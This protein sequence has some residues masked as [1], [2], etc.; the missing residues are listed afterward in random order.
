MRYTER[1]NR[2]RDDKK[3]KINND[4][5]LSIVLP[6]YNTEPNH[7]SEC[8]NSV[9][10]QRYS[11]WELCIVDDGSTLSETIHI[12]N[13][14]K[15]IDSRIKILTRT[16]NGHICVASNDAIAMSSGQFICFLDHDD[17]L[18]DFALESIFNCIKSNGDIKLI[19][20]DEDFID[21][22]NS[23]VSPHFKSDWNRTL[24]YS[25]N[26]ITHFVCVDSKII[27]EL[28]GLRI[29]SE[30]AQDFDLLLRLSEI[31][32]DTEICH[33]PEI[34][35]HWR[36]SDGSTASSSDAKTYTA[37][38]GLKSLERH[39]KRTNNDVSV[40][41]LTEANY[42]RV[43]WKIPVPQPLVSIII[44]TRD[45]FEILF[46][47]ISSILKKSS[48]SNYEIIIIDNES[49]DTQTLHYLTELS[50]R[51]DNKIRVLSYDIPFNF[52]KLNNYGVK[53]S[54]GELICFLN[55][56]TEV[57]SSDW[58][59]ELVSQVLRD[60]VGCVGAKL[61]YSNDTIQHAGV[62]LSIGG[63][64]GHSHKGFPR[65]SNGYFNRLKIAQELSA[66][67][68]ACLMVKKKIFNLVNGFD[69]E[70]LPVAYNDVDFCLKLR[71]KG[72]K[73]IWTPFAELFHHESVSRGYEDTPEKIARH[74]KERQYVVNKWKSNALRDPF[75]NINLT[76][77][78]E[79]FSIAL[80][81]GF[82]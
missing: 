25:H 18:S 58:L 3:K 42:F 60:D 55:N 33:I 77:D 37:S 21:R 15:N 47:C 19:Y 48:Y 11:N 32:E 59:E 44:P 65:N 62:I 34:L 4:I 22:N 24:L 40:E 28:Q 36:I 74:D 81:N 2:S 41:H 7:L 46:N 51:S 71:E 64:A 54:G 1:S 45:G 17:T 26:Y 73:V 35:Y 30:G 43:K 68:G 23:R 61:L 66:V 14:F 10:K 75:Y 80:P 78:R 67:T 38:A 5:L 50:S 72:L 52:S 56:D 39:F 16:T 8:I 6:V 49:T 82:N 53:E 70:N 20:S 13:N 27:K 79:D 12:L 57:I 29:G 31:L 76:R 9:L 69:E 63:L